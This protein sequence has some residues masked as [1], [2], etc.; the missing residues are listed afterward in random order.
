MVIQKKRRRWCVGAWVLF[1]DDDL[2]GKQSVATFL[3]VSET[4]ER[5][6]FP[7]VFDS[8]NP[9]QAKNGHGSIASYV[10]AKVSDDAGESSNLCRL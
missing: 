10:N 4:Y 1:V 5:A 9:G 8:R 7:V 6:T 3:K 2:D